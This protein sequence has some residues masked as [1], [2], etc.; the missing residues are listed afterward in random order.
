MRTL[1]IGGGASG[2]SEYAEELFSALEGT[3]YYIATMMPYGEDSLA[4][5][6]KHRKARRDR[7]FC[8]VEHYTDLAGL[9]L[10][11]KGAVL[12]ECLGNLTANELFHEGDSEKSAFEAI[13]RGVEALSEQSSDLVVVTNEVFSDGLDYD[14]STLA[15]IRTL[16]LINRELARRFDT[17]I[18]VVCGIPV[19][20]K[21]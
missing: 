10:P 6:E 7:G 16:A 12:L 11:T 19:A 14:E 15:Y 9:S 20:L 8:T 4:R 17:V 3:K 2:K 5:I 1:V 21:R 13:M 18:E